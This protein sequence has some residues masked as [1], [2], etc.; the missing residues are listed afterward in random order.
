VWAGNNEN[1]LGLDGYWF[2][3]TGV[4]PSMR[5]MKKDYMML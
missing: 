1:E 4:M 2:H 3:T 5:Q